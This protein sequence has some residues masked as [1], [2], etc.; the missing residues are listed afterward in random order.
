M[1]RNNGTGTGVEPEVKGAPETDGKEQ[2]GLGQPEGTQS[3][4]E[5]TLEGVKGT[6]SPAWMAQLPNDLKNEADLQ[7]YATLAD[8]VRSTMG[9][10]D[11]SEGSE[12]D[13]K[14][15]QPVKYEKFEKGLDPD[16]DPFGMI[17]ESLK[18]ML[19]ESGVSQAVAEKVFDTLSEAHKGTMSELITKGKD[20]CE[21]QLKK[22]WGDQYEERKAM[23][24]AYALVQSD[25]PAA[26]TVLGLHRP[27]RSSCCRGSGVHHEDYSRATAPAGMGETPIPVWTRLRRLN[28]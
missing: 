26:S 8:Y 27:I 1:D 5:N 11:G 15:T 22:S 14:G 23:T 17:T 16:S 18:G 6:A 7:Q 3:T 28:A 19:E 25:K 12:S 13:A 20:W 21:A 4:G 9:K 2:Q 24:R 10:T